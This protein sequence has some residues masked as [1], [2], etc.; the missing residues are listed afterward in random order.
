LAEIKVLHL[1]FPD[2]TEIPSGNSC[3]IERA[4]HIR[5]VNHL[6]IMTLKKS[7]L[8]PWIPCIMAICCALVACSGCTS[9]QQPVARAG[10]TVQVYYTV[11]LSDGTMIQS[12]RNDTPLEFTIGNGTVVPGFEEAIVGL[13][14]GQ[15]KTV[16][17]PP[18]K[19]YGL[20]RQELVSTLET[21]AVRQTIDE[22]EANKSL[23]LLTYPGI[24]EVYIWPRP[25]GTIGYLQFS[26]ITEETT[27]VDENHPLAGKDLVFEITLV[28]IVG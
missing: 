10:D 3:Q 20:Y 11:S 9:P 12:N 17:I 5:P 16:T 21:D 23:G 24:G 13:S 8:K 25:D 1:D 4:I 14:P 18:E 15:T 19:A 6:A 26:N 28:D 22:L 2:R 27:T 7:S